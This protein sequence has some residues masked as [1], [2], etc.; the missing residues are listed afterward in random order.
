MTIYQRNAYATLAAV[1]LV[2]GLLPTSNVEQLRYALVL[3]A[4]SS[5]TRIYAYQFTQDTSQAPQLPPRLPSLVAIPPDAAASKIPN[6]QHSLYERVET[7]PGIAAAVADP[8]QQR[9]KREALGPLLE[10][11]RAVVPKKQRACTPVFMFMTAGV[12][13]LS[14]YLQQRLTADTNAI[15]A[16]SGFRFSS[17]WAR[18]INGDEEGAFGWASVNYLRGRLRGM[19][20]QQ[21]GQPGAG[22]R[23]AH[24]RTVSAAPSP[25][26]LGTL[27]LGGSS[28][29]VVREQAGAAAPASA[30]AH[31]ITLGAHTYELQTQTYHRFGMGDT[32][33][34]SVQLLLQQYAAGQGVAVTELG[35]PG[36]PEV[37]L[38]HPCLQQ[39]YSQPH[40]LI[41]G[42]KVRANGTL[43]AVTLR[44]AFDE[45]RCTQLARTL[46]QCAQPSAANGTCS[47]PPAVSAVNAQAAAGGLVALTGFYVIWQ[48]FDALE[49]VP[50]APPA[51]YQATQRFCA[52]PW[53]D[54]N[55]SH[56]H[57]VNL[58]KYCLWGRYAVELLGEAGLDVPPAALAI[59]DMHDGWP[60]GAL[61]S[62]LTSE[63]PGSLSCR[64]P[65]VADALLGS[66]ARG[67]CECVQQGSGQGLRRL[68]WLLMVPVLMWCARRAH[69]AV[70]ARASLLPVV[71][72]PHA[73]LGNGLLARSSSGDC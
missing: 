72:P 45:A 69:L 16:S 32:F 4:G 35:A 52:Q 55:R 3:D 36:R 46:V 41:P 43:A 56:G 57:H 7:A 61:L 42:A 70:Q 9:L 38:E 22:A 23:D 51:L 71:R 11:A 19:A 18:I 53:P 59:G 31:S 62:M 63:V 29:E 6:K 47:G 58:E 15:L 2:L 27:D 54:V 20:S 5:G 12:R 34:R 14:P 24:A 44:G 10:W 68:A 25:G 49:P 26:T 66:W 67:R 13:K 30:Q 65:G 60:L 64:E 8:T 73:R 21:D 37:Q 48:F 1:C 17:R 50:Q 33:K 39:G 40:H 28:L